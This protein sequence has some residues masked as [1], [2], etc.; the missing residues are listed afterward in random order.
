MRLEQ[1]QYG[2][3]VLGDREATT[4]SRFHERDAR[5]ENRSGAASRAGGAPAAAMGGRIRMEPGRLAPPT[6]NPDS[7]AP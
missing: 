1:S 4:S 2:R 3:E 7:F 6:D 5:A